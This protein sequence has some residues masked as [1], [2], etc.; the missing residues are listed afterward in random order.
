MNRKS[1]CCSA[2]PRSLSALLVLMAQERAKV[3]TDNVSVQVFVPSDIESRMI[4]LKHSHF[5]FPFSFLSPD[6][7]LL[8]NFRL[9]FICLQV[10]R[11]QYHCRQTNHCSQCGF[12]LLCFMIHDIHDFC[13]A[14][15]RQH[16]RRKRRCL[17]QKYL[18]GNMK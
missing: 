6:S 11:L 16:G 17:V 15:Q 10:H 13:R 2:L 5:H 4:F 18:Q 3:S 8:F 14:L 12:I 7:R 1:F 9:L